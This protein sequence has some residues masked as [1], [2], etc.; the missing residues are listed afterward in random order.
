M[1]F[2]THLSE[3]ESFRFNELTSL[4]EVKP[5]VLR[6]WESEFDQIAPSMSSNG[7]KVYSLKDLDYLKRIRSLLF[8]QKCSIPEA[9]NILDQEIKS[10]SENLKSTELGQR[11]SEIK[12]EQ[13]DTIGVVSSQHSSLELMKQALEKDLANKEAQKVQPTSPQG[14]LS[15]QDI[16][17]LVQAKKKL[18]SI[19]K[20]VNDLA[21]QRNW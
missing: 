7:E 20:R 5:Y 6:F 2:E 1:N 13:D 21:D 3:K 8:D 14:Q 15:S 10:T 17:H 12:Q 19:I 11:F 9:K 4:V 18:T 16:V